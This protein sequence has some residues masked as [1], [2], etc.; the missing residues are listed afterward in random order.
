MSTKAPTFNRKHRKIVWWNNIKYSPFI[1]IKYYAMHIMVMF[2]WIMLKLQSDFFDGV[3]VAH[4]FSFLCCHYFVS[5]CSLYLFVYSGV[6]RILRFV[7]FVFVL[8]LV[9]PM[10]PVSLKCSFLIAPP[11]SLTFIHL[12]YL[13]SELWIVRKTFIPLIRSNWKYSAFEDLMQ[14][15]LWL[16]I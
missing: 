15:V 12:D 16:D 6:Q 7:L 3:R 11:V 5:L 9:Y 1:C 8:C 4:R 14:C 10:L 13:G 2:G